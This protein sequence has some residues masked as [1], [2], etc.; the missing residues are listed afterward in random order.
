MNTTTIIVKSWT[1]STSSQPTQVISMNIVKVQT[2]IQSWNFETSKLRISSCDCLSHQRTSRPKEVKPTPR[3]SWNSKYQ[4]WSINMIQ[5][6]GPSKNYILNT[7]MVIYV[8]RKYT[9]NNYISIIRFHW[10]E[11]KPDHLS[12]A[13]MIGKNLRSKTL[14]GTYIQIT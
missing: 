11:R 7:I 2:M 3:H 8:N 14:N 9:P 12:W 10:R 5:C 13:S 4:G 6:K 1:H